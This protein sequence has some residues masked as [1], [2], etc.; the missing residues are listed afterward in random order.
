MEP[1]LALSAGDVERAAK[2]LRAFPISQIGSDDWIAQHHVLEQM[3]VAAHANARSSS[4]DFVL[5]ALLTFEKLPL[6]IHELCAIARFRQSVLPCIVND[7]RLADSTSHV[8]L[9]FCLY[10]E[11]TILNLLEVGCSL[12][13]P[14]KQLP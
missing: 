13:F 1:H 11:A 2:A 7:N 6:L 5:A 4:D 3:N 8:R 12:L 10:H 14:P 9:Y